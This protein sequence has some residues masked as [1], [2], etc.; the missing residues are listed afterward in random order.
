MPTNVI[1]NGSF[2]VNPGN[3]GFGWTGTDLE[4]TYSE[5]TYQGN[6]S[7][8]SVAEVNGNA[9]QTTIMNQ[10]FTIDD[11]LVTE[12]TFEAAIRNNARAVV[13][14]DGYTVVITDSSGAIILNQTIYP[15]S[16]TFNQ[17]SFPVN[18][19]AAGDYTLSITELTVDNNSYGALI[20]DISI[21]VCL[22]QGAMIATPKGERAIETLRVGDIVT[23]QNG[24]KTLRWIGQRTVTATDLA[25]NDKLRPVRI[26][27]GAMGQGLPDRDMLVSRQH[28]MQTAS[29]IAARMFASSQVL[30]SAIRLTALP[31]IYVDMVADHV[32]YFHLLFDAHEI[33]FANGAPTE[34]LFTGPQVLNAISTEARQE[35]MALFPELSCDDRAHPAPACLIPTGRQQR[36]LMDRHIKNNKPV[37]VS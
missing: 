19:P 22:T 14:E 28:R 37:L 9:N 26:S 16:T 24:P 5:N 13:G 8:D 33:I 29:P 20:D 10:T 32:S 31:G 15:D 12:L 1:V 21:I 36:T 2:D 27:A 7:N 35:I 18:F 11:P 6:G 23:T 25:L 4:T 34:S 3:P 17:L 30:I